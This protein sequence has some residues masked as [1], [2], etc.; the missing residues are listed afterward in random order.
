M[1]RQLVAD[2]SL[3]FFPENRDL[4]DP[5]AL[6]RAFALGEYIKAGVYI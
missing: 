4:K 1:I 3:I 5:E 6:E 2:P